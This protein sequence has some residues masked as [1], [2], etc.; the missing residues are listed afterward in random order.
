MLILISISISI[1]YIY[2]YIKYYIIINNIIIL[3][4]H[5]RD[6][7]YMFSLNIFLYTSLREEKMLH[8]IYMYINVLLNSFSV[9]SQL[10]LACFLTTDE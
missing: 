9:N 5:F 1:F 2:I 3:G 10:N 7:V 8:I 4:Q 6:W